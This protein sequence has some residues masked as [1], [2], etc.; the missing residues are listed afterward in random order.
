[1]NWL[2]NTALICVSLL[3]T[4]AVCEGG[5][6]ALVSLGLIERPGGE[7]VVHSVEKTALDKH[8]ARKRKSDNSILSYEYDPS[9]PNINSLGLRGKETTVNKPEDV[10]RIALIGDSFAYGYSVA[11]SDI[12]ATQ[13][14]N[15]LNDNSEGRRYEI[16]NFGR[17]GY[18]TVQQAELYRTYI[19]QFDPD[20][21][22]LSYVL[23]DVTGTEF[24][25]EIFRADVAYRN[26]RD[27]LSQYSLLATWVYMTYHRLSQSQTKEELW[28]S[29]Y[30]DSSPEF[31]TVQNAL[32]ELATM[33][34]QDGVKRRAIIFPE[35]GA[36]AENYPYKEVHNVVKAALSESGFDTRDLL[37][38]YEQYSDW[39][40]LIVARDDQHPNS[41]GHDI[42]TTAIYEFLVD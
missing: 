40:E 5:I 36:D 7:S 10:Y 14:E 42:A 13:L 38:D 39:S 32:A 8:N 30:V 33:A 1:M 2:K 18:G 29:L 17:S 11:L 25:A 28:N 23:N 16:L 9:D 12:F 6:R 26:T 41:K 34:Q 19:R 22:L 3:F 37:P 35:L 24:L 27:Q 21:I 4:F 31:H 15:R 20:E